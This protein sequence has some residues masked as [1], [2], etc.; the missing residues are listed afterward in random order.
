[1]LVNTVSQE[2]NLGPGAQN[3]DLH[4]YSLTFL[5]TQT[6]T[7]AVLGAGHPWPVLTSKLFERS[8]GKR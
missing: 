6:L 5:Y 3:Q 8:L 4:L 1:M 2:L 7:L